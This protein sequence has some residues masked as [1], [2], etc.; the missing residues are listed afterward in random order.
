MSKRPSDENGEEGGGKKKARAGQEGSLAGSAPAPTSVPAGVTQ[1]PVPIV[2]PL[3][4]RVAELPKE[5]LAAA[6]PRG[7]GSEGA[8][9]SSFVNEES[10][11]TVQ[12][13]AAQQPQATWSSEEG[14]TVKKGPEDEESEMTENDIIDTLDEMSPR[15]KAAML[16]DALEELGQDLA[17][18]CEAQV[19]HLVLT[20]AQFAPGWFRQVSQIHLDET[21]EEIA[22]EL[23]G[24]SGSNSQAA[25][26]ALPPGPSTGPG[27]SADDPVELLDSSDDDAPPAQNHDQ[28]EGGDKP[29]TSVHE[30]VL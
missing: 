27:I 26:T 19:D 1:S 14:E 6:H 8:T 2:V 11:I 21:A 10:L 20:A 18:A 28:A 23:A 7:P 5:L 9:G 22:Q 17:I 16:Q 15:S 25:P 30:V 24:N 29:S 13:G 4:T 3:A 12:E